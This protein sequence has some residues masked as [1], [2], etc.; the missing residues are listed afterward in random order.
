MVINDVIKQAIPVPF[1]RQL[2]NLIKDR[3]NPI[4]ET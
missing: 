1:L 2:N 4:F 3:L